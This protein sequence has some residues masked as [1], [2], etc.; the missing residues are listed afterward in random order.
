MEDSK[1]LH[2]EILSWVGKEFKDIFENSQQAIYVYICDAH[3]TCNKKFL[4]MLGYDSLEEWTSKEEMLSDLVEEDQE[5]LVGA[6]RNA[7]ENFVGSS[8]NLAWKNKKSGKLVKTNV[9]LVPLMYS[10]ESFALHFITLL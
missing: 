10:G 3:R 5:K 1:E 9:I 4:S 6:Y 2:E 7:M 8:Q